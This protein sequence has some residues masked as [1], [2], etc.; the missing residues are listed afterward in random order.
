MNRYYL[1]KNTINGLA[2]FA[3]LGLVVLLLTVA[4]AEG[5]EPS[6][7][8]MD[9]DRSTGACPLEDLRLRTKL[10]NFIS[11]RSGITPVWAQ[12]LKHSNPIPQMAEIQGRHDIRIL[13]DPEDTAACVA[14]NQQ[15]EDYFAE[16]RT[17]TDSSGNTYVDYIYDIAYYKAV[18]LYFAVIVHAPLRQPDDPNLLQFTTA[19][20]TLIA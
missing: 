3:M 14:L 10:G 5:Q 19:R 9:T 8:A 13:E 11:P 18:G 20:G 7:Q 1:Y 17:T 2:C 6:T 15:L 16:T 12:T 4:H